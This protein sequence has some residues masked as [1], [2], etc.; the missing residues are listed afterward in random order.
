MTDSAAVAQS[1]YAVDVVIP[2]PARSGRLL[3][4]FRGL[5]LIPQVIF[6]LVVILIA[7]VLLLINYLVVLITGRAAFFG[8]LSGMV[9]YSA[10]LTA[11]SYLL[12]DK[13]P[14]FS[15]G[16]SPGY[17]VQITIESPGHIHRWRFFSILLALP[18]IL[19]LYALLVLTSV[20][21]LI[22]AIV[23]LIVGRYP[24]GLFGLAVATIR[25]ETRVNAYLYLITSDYPPFS[26]S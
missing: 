25:H 16:D 10:R 18:H 22:S 3:M 11:Y 19:V 23:I 20:T 12:T 14:P 4:I 15:L 9:Q 21:T 2:R 6:A 8:F 5:L 24:P 26:L 17:P 13:Y 1:G 7:V